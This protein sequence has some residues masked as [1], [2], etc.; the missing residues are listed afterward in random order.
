MA[1]IAERLIDAASEGDMVALKELGDRLDGKP[2]QAIDADIRGNL[3]QT[4][5]GLPKIEPSAS[6]VSL[7]AEPGHGNKPAT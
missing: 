3:T 6:K 2:V 5:L 7:I 4:L 1:A